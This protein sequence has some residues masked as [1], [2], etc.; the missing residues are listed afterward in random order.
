MK[1]KIIATLLTLVMIGGISIPARADDQSLTLTTD[2]ASTYT[3]TI[4]ANQAIPSLATSTPI[5]NIQ[6]VG[7]VQTTEEVVVTATKTDFTSATQSTTIPFVIY[8]NSISDNFTSSIWT[9][10]ELISATPKS[11]PLSIN[12]SAT[13]WQ[14]ARASS[15]SA[16]ITFT[17][18][19]A[20]KS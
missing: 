5:G 8:N 15:Y 16:T 19:I 9:D 13:D 7:D 1:K 14:N 6:V 10:S 11:V 17:A 18:A 2:V 12:I 3:L 20:P 4:P